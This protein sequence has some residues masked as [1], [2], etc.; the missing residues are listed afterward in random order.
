MAYLLHTIE[1]APETVRTELEDAQQRFGSVPN[2]YR[3]LA[4]SPAALKV[5]LAFNENL[6]EYGALSAVEQQVVYLTVS[7]ENGC[8][9]CVGA[10]STLASMA[11][12]P[13]KILMELR[14]QKPL[15]DSRLEVLRRVTLSLMKNS[16]WLPDAD[17]DLFSGQ[18]FERRHL[19]EVITIVA[20]KTLSNYF[21]HIADTPLDDM[22]APFAWEPTKTR[23]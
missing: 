2:L 9:Y 5:Y 8:T 12:M 1:S 15:S 7:A 13:E 16:G 20:Q 18:G 21:N 17:A 23:D 3:A 6:Q 14:D 22:F 11:K 10:H 4:E 19:I